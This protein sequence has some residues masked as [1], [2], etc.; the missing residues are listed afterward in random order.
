MSTVIDQRKNKFW[1]VDCREKLAQGN[2]RLSC[3]LNFPQNGNIE[4]HVSVMF[5]NYGIVLFC[6]VGHLMAYL[7]IRTLSIESTIHPALK[8]ERRARQR[9]SSSDA[10]S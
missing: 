4:F 10:K 3:S 5:P 6:P 9:Y 1:D 7:K 2:S 8:Q